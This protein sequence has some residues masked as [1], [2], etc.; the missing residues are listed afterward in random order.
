[1]NRRAFGLQFLNE[2]EVLRGVK[3]CLK[4]IEDEVLRGS[5]QAKVISRSF[6][7]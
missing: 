2:F 4:D 5:D 3:K 1:M 7:N 6:L